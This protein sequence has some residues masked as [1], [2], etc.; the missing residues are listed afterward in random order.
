[1][2]RNAILAT[3]L[4]YDQQKSIHEEIV[5]LYPRIAEAK[6]YFRAPSFDTTQA[7]CRRYRR[8][9]ARAFVDRDRAI[10]AIVN[11]LVTTQR[12]VF[13]LC[14]STWATTL[15]HFRELRWRTP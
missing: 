15:M 5:S 4:D 8:R 13:L 2:Q 11:K 12:A 9:V 7:D 1:M 14:E 10:C 6:C 3:M